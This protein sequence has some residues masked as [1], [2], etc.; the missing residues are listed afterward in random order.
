[1]QSFENLFAE[2]KKLIDAVLAEPFHNKNKSY[3]II[4]DAMEY[5]VKNGGKAATTITAISTR[6]SNTST[7]TT[8][9]T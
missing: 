3:K 1:M 4:I 5:S 9:R 7:N 8:A 2:R 6:F